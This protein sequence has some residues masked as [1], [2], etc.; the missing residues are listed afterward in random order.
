MARLVLI[1]SLHVIIRLEPRKK[2]GTQRFLLEGRQD[3]QAR[4]RGGGQGT[5]G[6]SGCR[7]IELAPWGGQDAA[8]SNWHPGGVR[9]PP[10]RIGTL[11]GQIELRPLEA[12]LPCWF[13]LG[14]M[15]SLVDIGIWRRIFRVLLSHGLGWTPSGSGGEGC[16]IR[17]I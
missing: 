12:W 4:Q 11:G 8:K 6:G 3:M 15:G 1:L 10:N 5:L 7:Q 2:A 13:I 14:K 17:E 16:D 9:M